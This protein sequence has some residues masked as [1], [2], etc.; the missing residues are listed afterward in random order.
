M[1]TTNVSFRGKQVPHLAGTHLQSCKRLV[2][3]V[4]AVLLGFVLCAFQ[5]LS[6]IQAPLSCFLSVLLPW[7]EL[8]PSTKTFSVL[9]TIFSMIKHSRILL[10]C[11]RLCANFHTLLCS[12]F[13]FFCNRGQQRLCTKLGLSSKL[14]NHI[15]KLMICLDGTSN[16]NLSVC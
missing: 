1:V 12:L 3:S 13:F 9:D 14:P 2:A 15:N 8:C 5:Y 7:V 11:I 6:N 4:C 10:K 16:F